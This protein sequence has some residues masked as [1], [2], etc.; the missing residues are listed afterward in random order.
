MF[1]KQ[2]KLLASLPIV[3]SSR[4]WIL[5]G[6]GPYITDVHLYVHVATKAILLG[7]TP[8]EQSVYGDPPLSLPFISICPSGFQGEAIFDHR[9]KWMRH[10][11][12]LRWPERRHP[13]RRSLDEI[14][15]EEA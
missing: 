1:K 8:Y 3:L 2:W 15:G 14:S 6:W 12:R 7:V 11:L 10:S 9:V 5:L 4:L 13:V